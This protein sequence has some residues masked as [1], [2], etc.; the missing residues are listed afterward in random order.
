MTNNASFD[1]EQYL[2]CVTLVPACI[3]TRLPFHAAIFLINKPH[4]PDIA[5]EEHTSWNDNDASIEQ[6]QP[7]T[8]SDTLTEFLRTLNV[9]SPSS[10]DGELSLA[11]SPV[12]T[13]PASNILSW[14]AP[15]MMFPMLPANSIVCG[16]PLPNPSS[17]FD[18]SFGP[19]VQFPFTPSFANA[20]GNGDVHMLTSAGLF[21]H[22]HNHGIS[23]SGTLRT[24]PTSPPWIDPSSPS[25]SASS[26][27]ETSMAEDNAFSDIYYQNGY[28]SAPSPSAV[29]YSSS[30]SLSSTRR[31]A[32]TRASHSSG[33]YRPPTEIAT[34][35]P[36]P[37]FTSVASRGTK[38]KIDLFELED[39]TLCDHDDEDGDIDSE[40]D[41]YQP[42]A[43][44][45]SEEESDVDVPSP[46]SVASSSKRSSISTTIVPTVA[47]TSPKKNH[48]G[49]KPRETASKKVFLNDGRTKAVGGFVCGLITQWKGKGG[50]YTAKGI[51]TPEVGEVCEMRTRNW[52]DMVRHQQN[53]FWHSPPG[54]CKSCKAKMN[55]RPDN[56]SRHGR[57][58][59]H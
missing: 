59:P 4:S 58:Y 55:D 25:V 35:A 38:R 39:S 8:D 29:S 20:Y 2:L 41:E 19:S 18:T 10:I 26:P 48:S 51:R 24:E 54:A 43:H 46:S 36:P 27:S 17:I 50:Q 23:P 21:M 47:R 7:E 40:E 33:V 5:M 1:F 37:K 31:L 28:T 34:T 56:L 11:P 9:Q 53:T 52:S 42:T 44:S 16:I 57:A 14:A 22:P 15:A 6:T 13:S 32:R 45:D 49:S 30:S 3:T 12:H